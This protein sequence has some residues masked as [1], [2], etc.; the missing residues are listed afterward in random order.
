[1]SGLTG[2]YYAGHFEGAP[3]LDR[4]DPAIDFD[5]ADEAPREDLDDD[6]FSVRWTGEVVAPATGWH[7]LA[8]R[9]AT[10]CRLFID[11]K[12]IGQARGD[13]EPALASGRVWLRAGRSYP[14][15]V[16]LEHD[17]Y[18]AEAQLLW[19]GP[20][21][22]AGEVAAAV[23][24]LRRQTPSCSCSAWPRGSRAR[25]WGSPST[26]FERR[27]P[28]EPRP[29]EGAARAHDEVVTEAAGKPVVLV[30]MSGS[31]L[32][33]TW[34][35]EHVPAIVQAW[36]PGQAGGTAVAD[37]LFGDVSPG[38]PS[39]G[40][41]LPLGRPAAA[42]RRLRDE[43][44]DVPVLRRAR[45]STRSATAS[46]TPASPT[47]TWTSRHGAGGH[48][49]G[50]L[51]PGP[52]RG[53]ADRGRGGAAVRDPPGRVGAGPAAGPQG[54][55]PGEPEAGG[56][57]D[58]SIHPLPAGPVAGDRG[59]RARRPARPP[60]PRRRRQAAGHR[61]RRRDHHRGLI[62]ELEL[63]GRRQRLAPDRRARERPKWRSLQG[64]ARP[65]PFPR[66][67]PPLWGGGARAAPS[68]RA[69]PPP[70]AGRAP[71]EGRT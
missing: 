60:R 16:E 48:P 51:G 5:W 3:V 14:I 54:V 59:G 69:R 32:A 39:A 27:R 20:G 68:R 45:R 37:V 12:P 15:R 25:R 67:A 30:L 49:G 21:P 38:G 50:G 70:R 23:A 18:D 36:Y 62:A 40:H 10:L 55:S 35:D 1:M 41:L 9:C 57:E 53:R 47:T 17:K 22:G 13:H 31:A 71:D 52:E 6:S 44:A 63:S 2:A 42:V 46:A 11:D 66:G 29:S 26:G 33:V 24:R 28:D 56:E 64:R 34:A 43:G 58:G 7:T 19:D 61:H 4:V 8:V 65:A